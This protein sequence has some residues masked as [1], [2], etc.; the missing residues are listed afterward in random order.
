MSRSIDFSTFARWLQE[1]WKLAIAA[2]IPASLCK[3]VGFSPPW[4]DPTGLAG[5]AIAVLASLIGV[6]VAFAYSG[7]RLN[8]SHGMLIAAAGAVCCLGVYLAFW[9]LFVGSGSQTIGSNHELVRTMFVKGT[10]KV[11]P[12]PMTEEKDV[13]QLHGYRVDEVYTSGSLLRNRLILLISFSGTFFFLTIALGFAPFKRVSE[14]Q[15]VGAANKAPEV[16]ISYAWGDESPEGKVRTQA[17]D[18]LQA[19][20]EK[21]GFTP[22]RDLDQIRTGER[23]SAFIRRLTRA[24]LVVAVISDK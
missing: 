6:V 22:V 14:P 2:V 16:Y 10:F 18:G 17:V 8:A 4:P 19:A 7:T 3:L 15:P 12:A 11:A 1:N 23:I 9:S 13:L 5:C 20:L 21:D 24:D